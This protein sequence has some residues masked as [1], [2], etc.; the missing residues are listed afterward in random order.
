MPT[1][2]ATPAAISCPTEIRMAIPLRRN[3]GSCSA[4]RTGS[5]PCRRR[6]SPSP[7]GTQPLSVVGIRHDGIS[8]AV[9]T[10]YDSPQ[11]LLSVFTPD[12][13]GAPGTPRVIGSAAVGTARGETLA[14]SGRTVAAGAPG[15]T[16]AGRT[17]AGE[18]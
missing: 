13:F 2:M 7:W 6:H 4:A 16:V 18:S 8:R 10:G 9:L 15:L 17:Q 12:A 11:S 14:A 1:S 3:P 5:T